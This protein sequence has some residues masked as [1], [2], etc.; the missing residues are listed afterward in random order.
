MSTK[1]HANGPLIFAIVLCLALIGWGYHTNR[2]Y[3]QKCESV[4]AR[5]IEVPVTGGRTPWSHTASV[6]VKNGIVV[7]PEEEKLK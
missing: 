4:G 5:V 2:E 3:A 7:D 1:M 6:C